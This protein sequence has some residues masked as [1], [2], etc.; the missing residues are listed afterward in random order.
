[1]SGHRTF[2]FEHGDEQLGRGQQSTGTVLNDISEVPRS[3]GRFHPA[4]HP[5]S[6]YN[7][8]RDRRGNVPPPPL[9]H[10]NS[11]RD[12][13]TPGMD[14]LGAAAVGGGIGG[15]ALGVANSHGRE[16]GLQAMRGVDDSA[17]NLYMSGPER[18]SFAGPGSPRTRDSYASNV[19]LGAAA[20]PTGQGTPNLTPNQSERSLVDQY[21]TSYQ[22]AGVMYD[23]PYQGHLSAYGSRANPGSINPEE[24]LDDGDDGFIPDPQ[25]K[26]VLNIGH[27]SNNDAVP[28]GA[29]G[30]AAGG[31]L[32]AI[33][34]MMKGQKGAVAGPNYDP[35]PGSGLE[36]G[37]AEKSDWLRRQTSGRRKMGWIV[38]ITL[39][40]IIVGAIVGGAVGGVLGSRR[41]GDPD[42]PYGDSTD[43]A[44]DDAKHNGDLG[45]DSS[46]I[47]ALMNNKDLHKVFPGMDYTPWGVQYPLC[48][49]YPPSQ[50]NVT[51]DMAVLSQL[52]NQVR[53]Y[54]T[55]C[56]QT[57][58]VLHAINRLELTDMK[59]WLGVW[60][61]T[62]TTTNERQ[63]K[64]LYKVLDETEDKSIFKGAII[65]NEALYRAGPDIATAQTNLINYLKSVRSNFTEKKIDL[66]I[67]TSDLGDN[68]NKELV[69]A[70]DI[71]MSNIHPFF[72]GVPVDQAASWVYEFWTN[73]DVSLTKGTN[74]KQI[75]SEVGWPSGG[76]N[77][78]GTDATCPNSKAGSVAGV[79]E[80]NQF[81]ADFVCQAVNNGTD[82]FW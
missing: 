21:P 35:V 82:F 29:G 14:D 26:S 77:D 52:T 56:N 47:Q 68:W 24:I 20:A 5:D 30:A 34:G 18:G 75:I 59:V 50:N 73:H 6:A 13:V 74:K 63:L 43:T 41:H 76:G 79:D 39:G 72:G 2:S 66:P 78:C 23:G 19:P 48:L 64:Q 38:G 9:P 33:G 28:A 15:I 54:G 25:R 65:G 60:L 10:G 80:M 53:L 8:M 51:R 58:M 7:R 46:E 11:G 36:S 31:M 3:G 16:S 12:G 32:G 42:S 69:E 67:A 61:D 4:S 1:M 81:M 27:K 45:K 44:T 71:V 62:N 40:V 70:V 55:D 37:A 17:D 49:K 22:G 57:E